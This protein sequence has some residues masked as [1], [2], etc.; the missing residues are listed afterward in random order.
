MKQQSLL[1]IEIGN[2]LQK[3]GCILFLFKPPCSAEGYKIFYPK[4]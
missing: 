3:F 4:D 1:R 2:I